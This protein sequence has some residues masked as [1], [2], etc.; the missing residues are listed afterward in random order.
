[1]GSVVV[2]ESE[3]RLETCGFEATPCRQ[4]A[5]GIPSVVV[6][7]LQSQSTFANANAGGDMP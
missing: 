2:V 7:D 4:S 5:E 6:L 3:S 1:M